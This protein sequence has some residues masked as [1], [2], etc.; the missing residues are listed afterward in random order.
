MQRQPIRRQLQVL[1]VS[2]ACPVQPIANDGMAQT[3]QV[4]AYL[5]LAP[6]LDAHVHELALAIANHFLQA[7]FANR[8]FAIDRLFN[9]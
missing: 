7:K 9:E 1:P 8:I 5:V 6:G 3:G 4:T 2:L